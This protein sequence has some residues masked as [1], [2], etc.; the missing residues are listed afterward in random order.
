MIFIRG[1]VFLC[2]NGTWRKITGV[3]NWKGEI[4]YVSNSS[5]EDTVY[6]IK[7]MAMQFWCTYHDVREVSDI[8]TAILI[9]KLAELT[10]S[11]QSKGLHFAQKQIQMALG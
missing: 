11:A 4:Y 8:K 7:N 5:S 2:S 1:Q 10:I 6:S 3:N 9:N